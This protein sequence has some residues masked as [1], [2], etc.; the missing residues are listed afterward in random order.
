MH[1]RR[2]G[3]ETSSAPSDSFTTACVALSPFV[4][5]MFPAMRVKIAGLDP[6]QQY[7]IA[8][9][10]VPVDNKRYRYRPRTQVHE[11]TWMTTCHVPRQ[12]CR[13]PLN[14]V[15]C[16]FPFYWPS[17]VQQCI[18]EF[19]YRTAVKPKRFH[20]LRPQRGELHFLRWTE[21]C[22]RYFAATTRTALWQNT[23]SDRG[24]SRALRKCQM[25]GCC[26]AAQSLATEVRK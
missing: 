7:Y 25:Y 19:L 26:T 6:H 23:P 1:H 10:I 4:R 5:R 11:R 2:K 15:A 17:K 24:P 3:T 20:S 9:D 22:F 18:P 14:I 8:M 12:T 16:S 21:R 13:P